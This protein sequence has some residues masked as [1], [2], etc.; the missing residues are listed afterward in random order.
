MSSELAIDSESSTN[1]AARRGAVTTRSTLARR[2]AIGD[3]ALKGRG[4][5][6]LTTHDTPAVKRPRRQIR[7]D[8][9]NEVKASSGVTGGSPEGPRRRKKVSGGANTTSPEASGEENKAETSLKPFRKKSSRKAARETKE[10]QDVETETTPKKPKRKR[11]T[12]EE[13][14]AEAMPLAV[15]TRG[16]KVLIGA[17]VSAA[18]GVQNAVTNGVHIGGN[19]FALFLKSQRKWQSP[20]IKPDHCDQFKSFVR[21]YDFDAQRHIVPHGS[22]LVNLAQDDAG[23]AAQAYDCFLEDLQRCELLGI[24]LYNF[25]PGSTLGRPRNEALARI[26][27]ALNRAHRAT[28]SVKTLLENMA[29]SGNI[30]GSTFEDLRDIIA[31]IDDKSRVG[32]C[33]DTC[34]AFAAGYDLRTPAAFSA[35]LRTFSDV[36][37]LSYLSALHLNDSK[38]PLNSHRDLHQNIGLGFLGLSAFRNVVNEPAF[39]GLPMVLETPLGDRGDEVEIWAK[40]IKLLESLI[41]VPP[42]DPGFL[43]KESELAE[44]GADERKKYQELFDRQAEKKSKAGAKGRRRGKKAELETEDEVSSKGEVESDSEGV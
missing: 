26:A 23:K 1:T 15:R 42:D 38:T 10:E 7:V 13:K 35:T 20:A 22:Y 28:S 39:E 14:E 43:A 3:H 9:P 16:L 44:Q 5:K 30:I 19:S 2:A 37:G 24:G 36:I 17:H 34:H 27:S 32:V 25:H 33:L 29:G 6:R 8:F 40:E 31:L 12:K 21:E 4:R 18:K 11:K 41:G